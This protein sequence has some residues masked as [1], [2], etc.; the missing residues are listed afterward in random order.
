MGKKRLVLRI[1]FSVIG[2]LLIAFGIF[3]NSICGVKKANKDVTSLSKKDLKG[4]YTVELA[5]D[6]LPAD[7][8][9]FIF[10]YPVKK[11]EYAHIVFHVPKNQVGLLTQAIVAGYTVDVKVGTN[12]SVAMD[13][14]QNGI[15]DYYKMLARTDDSIDVSLEGKEKLRES[16]SPY[17]LKVLKINTPPSRLWQISSLVLGGIILLGVILEIISRLS[18]VSLGKLLLIEA[19]LVVVCIAVVFGVFYN[20]IRTLNSVKEVGK[21]IYSMTFYGDLKTLDLMEAGVNTTDDLINWVSEE[22]LNG[23]PLYV[24]TSNFGCSAFTCETTKGDVIFGRN[25]D[26]ENTEA[27]VVY[28]YPSEGYSFV[29]LAGLST[30]GLGSNYGLNPTDMDCRKYLMAAPYVVLDGVN[31]KGLGVG[32]LQLNIDELHQD[33]NNDD[34]LIYTVIHVLL[35]NCKDVDEAVDLLENYDIHTSL[36]F[37]YHLYITDDSGNSVVV[38]WLDNEMVVTETNACTNSVIA[39]GP[40]HNEGGVDSRLGL[41]D[42][43]LRHDA[44]LSEDDARD[45]LETVSQN[46]TQWSCVYNLSD[47]EVTVYLNKNYKKGYTFTL[48]QGDR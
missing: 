33:Q 10:R 39:D 31:E 35:N 25:F 17:D 44:K 40:H 2:V 24:C 5:R 15:V 14:Y 42:R 8:N 28:S 1:S 21:G 46:H 26:Y 36:G 9:L 4:E 18:K 12:S 11:G 7:D 37:S 34:L 23:E 6:F 19:I 43:A 47:R 41:I 38:E 20:K 22:Q 30:F 16:V 13:L 27:I 45:L 29:G 32:I 3:F 48:D